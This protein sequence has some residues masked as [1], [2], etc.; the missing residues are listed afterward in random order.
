MKWITGHI[1]REDGLSLAE[2]VTVVSVLGFVLAAAWAGF[3]AFQKADSIN[4]VQAQ[5]AHD[6]SDPMEWVSKI[7]MQAT[8]IDTAGT[9]SNSISPSAYQIGVWTNRD[10]DTTPELNNIY[11][12]TSGNLVWEYWTYD[13]SRTTTT[14]HVKWVVSATNANRSA[15]VPLFT[16]WDANGNQITDMSLA[17]SSTY[18]VTVT[19][20]VPGSSGGTLQDSRDI[21]LRNKR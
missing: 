4:T 21:T 9:T 2:F 15:G 7:V 17:A 10:S 16:Y 11:V 12:D 18:R 6:F 14:K 8:A 3:F 13:S 19:L 20:A 1:G 5:A